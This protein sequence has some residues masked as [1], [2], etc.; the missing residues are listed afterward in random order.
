MGMSMQ[1]HGMGMSGAPVLGAP[2]TLGAQGMSPGM[3]PMQMQQQQ[4]QQQNFMQQQHFMQ[5][6]QRG[7]PPGAMGGMRPM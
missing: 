7:M 2:N 5:L 4:Q 3:Q 1:Q 6:Q